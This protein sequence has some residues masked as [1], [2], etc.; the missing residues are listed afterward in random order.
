MAAR[1]GGPRSV[2]EIVKFGGGPTRI[3]R[4]IGVSH[5]TACV[6]RRSGVPEVY[7]L[8]FVELGLVLDAEELQ[9]AGGLARELRGH[10][11]YLYPLSDKAAV[12][13]EISIVSP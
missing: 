6:W 2:G 3:G 1:T 4:Q 12:E 5:S 10:Y 7:G 8:R 9:A 13:S 11:T